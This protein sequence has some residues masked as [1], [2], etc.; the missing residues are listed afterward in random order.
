[1]TLDQEM[2]Q[3]IQDNPIA[4]RILREVY[5]NGLELGIHLPWSVLPEDPP[6]FTEALD[7]LVEADLMTSSYLLV[8]IQKQPELEEQIVGMLGITKERNYPPQDSVQSLLEYNARARM[9]PSNRK[10][11][12]YQLLKKYLE[13]RR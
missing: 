3:R 13:S 10:V 6:E 5:M 1:M 11:R 7:L 12:G 8:P 9:G 4:I 2:I